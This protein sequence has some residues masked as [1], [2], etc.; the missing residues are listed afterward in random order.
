M[1]PLSNHCY[2]RE[3]INFWNAI[4]VYH[5]HYI[6]LK[7]SCKKYVHKL[8]VFRP[9][10]QNRKYLLCLFSASRKCAFI[11]NLSWHIVSLYKSHRLYAAEAARAWANLIM[12]KVT[13]LSDGPGVGPTLIMYKTQFIQIESI[14]SWRWSTSNLS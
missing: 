1:K 13:G 4:F 2:H 14:I 8:F 6:L 7:K 10:L 5:L 11:F 3:N 9:N 12:K